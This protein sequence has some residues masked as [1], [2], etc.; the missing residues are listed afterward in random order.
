MLYTHRQILLDRE[1]I[2]KFNNN[3][4]LVLE[5]FYDLTQD[6]EPIQYGVYQIIKILLAKY[7]ISIKQLPFS[8]DTFDCGYQELI[9]RDRT[10]GGEVYDAVKQ[11]PA[12]IRLVASPLHEALFAQIRQTDALGIAA[13]GYGIRIDN[14]FEEKYRAPWHQDYPAQFRSLDG[15][16][17]WSPL[18][19][20]TEAL[21]PIEF[22]L[23]SHKDGLRRVCTKDIKNPEKTGAYG[24]I[25]ENEEEVISHYPHASPLSKPGDLIVVDFLTLHASGFNRGKRSRW[26]MQNRYFNYNDPTGI[27]IS[28]RGSFASNN[29]IKDIHPELIADKPLN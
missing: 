6:I 18:V 4:L 23:G 14:P 7:Q 28:W 2:D 20:I 1:Q 29:S 17:F 5:N 12:F 9:A 16:V 3:G 15:I 27:K 11:I 26:S 13:G 21:G 19:P 24:L 25:L 8:P 10:I 22:C